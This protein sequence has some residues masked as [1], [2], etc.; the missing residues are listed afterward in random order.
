MFELPKTQRKAFYVLSYWSIKE[1]EVINSMQ[2]LMLKI[3]VRVRQ[4]EILRS[5]NTRA[6]NFK[7][8]A[9]ITK[10]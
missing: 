8:S 2:L 1:L 7:I 10:L 5:T 4:W 6:E 9:F 3:M